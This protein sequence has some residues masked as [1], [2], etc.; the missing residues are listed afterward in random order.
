M[1]DIII[2]N[3]WISFINET[4]ILTIV[5]FLYFQWFY[6]FCFIVHVYI[7]IR[8]FCVFACNYTFFFYM[9]IL[10][11]HVYFKYI[12]SNAIFYNNNTYI[13]VF[14]YMWNRVK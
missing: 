7:V 6:L 13:E 4:Y 2:A 3:L 8:H 11:I 5:F 14:K 12:H 10:N 9:A 1:S